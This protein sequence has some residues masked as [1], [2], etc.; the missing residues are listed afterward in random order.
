M[1]SG[2]RPR[3]HRKTLLVQ[4]PHAPPAVRVGGRVG[5]CAG[6]SSHRLSSHVFAI[7]GQAVPIIQVNGSFDW[8]AWIFPNGTR[9]YGHLELIMRK[10]KPL[11]PINQVR[12]LNSAE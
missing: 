7:L 6:C 11:P 4:T 8:C 2:V 12:A 3:K 9:Q 1:V 10:T 5:R